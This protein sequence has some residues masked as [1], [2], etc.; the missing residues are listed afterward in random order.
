MYEFDYE[1]VLSKEETA[2]E[3]DRDSVNNADNQK[4]KAA[5]KTKP[6]GRRKSGYS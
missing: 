4:T 5:Q 1:R 3:E 2:F 6:T